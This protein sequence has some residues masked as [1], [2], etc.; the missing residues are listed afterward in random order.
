MKSDNTAVEKVIPH[1]NTQDKGSVI[2]PSHRGQGLRVRLGHPPFNAFIGSEVSLVKAN[3]LI[4]NA[5][6]QCA[7]KSVARMRHLKIAK[8]VAIA[9]RI[10]TSPHQH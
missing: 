7:P 10:T 6:E 5:F 9:W 3:L 1:C 2:N 4:H 8:Q